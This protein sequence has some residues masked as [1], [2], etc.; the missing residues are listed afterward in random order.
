VATSSQSRV[1]GDADIGPADKAQAERRSQL[2]LFAKLGALIVCFLV[3][4]YS[5][6]LGHE[7]AYDD[8]D[9]LNQTADVMAGKA[10]FWA[11]MFR[12]QGEHLGTG[13]RLA[14]YGCAALFGADALPMR[15]LAL[16][17]HAA[18]ALM[19]ALVARRYANATAA[20]ATAFA[21]VVPAG[22]SSMCLWFPSSASVPFGLFFLTAATAVVA[23]QKILGRRAAGFAAGTAVV[24]ALLCESTLAPLVLVPGLV[25]GYERRRQG[26]SP[27]GIFGLFCLLSAVLVALAVVILY[28]FTFGQRP[29]LSLRHGLPRAV[30]LVLVAPF[31]FFFPGV[32]IP[33]EPGLRTGLLGV[34][35]GT[36]V[37]APVLAL[38]VALWR[39]GAPPLARL[40]ALAAAGPAGYVVL[41]GLGR[42]RSTYWE[43]YDADR[44]FFRLLVP[45]ALLAGAVAASAAERL[46]CWR[47]KE[48]LML[49][50]LVALAL[51]AELVLHRR[52]MSSRVPHDI[53]AAHARRLAA[54]ERLSERLTAAALALPADSPPLAFPDARLWFPDVHDGYLSAR[55]LLHVIGHGAGERLR[56][57]GPRIG[58]RDEAVLNEVLTAWAREEREHLP[59]LSVVGG[60]LFDAHLVCHADFRTSPAESAVVGGFYA[61]E[62][63]SR[64]MSRRGELRLT[65]TSPEAVLELGAPRDALRR[66]GVGPVTLA[67]TLVDEA[68]ARPIS[69]GNVAVTGEGV[70]PYALS[71][72]PFLHV[73]GNGRIVRLV[74]EADRVWKPSEVLEGASDTRDLSVQVF[75]AGFALPQTPPSR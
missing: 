12:P 56:L 24:L 40:A 22:F 44:Y 41:V 11:T 29:G 59:Y 19:L 47:R 67:V 73:F 3:V 57:G 52:G 46:R 69:L 14:L 33:S 8:I 30:F 63:A 4:F 58:P 45:A 17:S 28:Q 1:T 70:R 62:G 2:A 51:G 49:L 50:V 18:A 48:R 23:H 9:Y 54:L 5:P 68:T 36:A 72:L 61:W 16:L 42:W 6:T 75:G 64:W 65:M 55:F 27:I 32:P 37:G 10:G 15:L 34:F 25:D 31:R 38:L 66:V 7:Y 60:E 53:Y 35:L 71:A 13:M 26:R 43:L 21:Y 39:Q 74:L 20:C